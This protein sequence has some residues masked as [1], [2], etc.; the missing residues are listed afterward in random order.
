MTSAEPAGTH[1]YDTGVGTDAYD[2]GLLAPVSAGTAAERAT[3]DRAFLQAMLDAEAALTRAQAALGHAPGPAAEAVTEAARADRFDTRDLALRARAGGNPVIPLVTALTAAVPAHAAPYVHRGATSQDVLDTATMLVAARTLPLITA[4]LH[5]AA[6]AFGRLAAAHRDTPMAGRT[7][8]QHAVPTTFGLKATGWRHLALDAADRLTALRLPA[9]LGG[10][11][12]TLAAFAYLAGAPDSGPALSEHYAAE[13]GLAAPVLPWHT[14]RTP[15]ADLATALAFTTAA[16]GKPAVDV[17]LLARTETAELAEGS[18][19][20]SSAM[21]HKSNPVR[22]TLVASAARQ[23]PALAAVLLG[24]LAA[25]DERPAG[26]WHAEWQPLRDLL[27]LAGS[28]A[29]HTAELA[30][31]L[32]VRPDRMLENLHRTR[33]LVT[34]ERLAAALADVLGRDEA[35]ALLDRLSRRAAEEDQELA[36]L[37]VAAPELIGRITSERLRTLADPAG[38]TGAASLLVDHALRRQPSADP[39]GRP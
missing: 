25:E 19:G 16:L 26:A 7:L 33:G 35:R 23:A 2:V 4:E 5:R 29:H 31:G 17:L 14:L 36:E 1:G 30:E 11:A 3:G 20:G 21:P 38:A 10:A 24:S 32:R 37:L 18:G 34:S 27:R 12:G 28:A 9:Q 22:A 6:E 13:L 8:G 39:E 15:I